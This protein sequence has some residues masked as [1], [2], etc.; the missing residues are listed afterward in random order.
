MYDKEEPFATCPMDSPLIRRAPDEPIVDRI[1]S[2][3]RCAGQIALYGSSEANENA[4]RLSKLIGDTLTETGCYSPAALLVD[5]GRTA[6]KLSFDDPLFRKALI[7]A[8][9]ARDEA[10]AKNKQEPRS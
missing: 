5:L 2:P 4:V 1:D 7:K 3:Q 10:I 9:E 6:S 8:R